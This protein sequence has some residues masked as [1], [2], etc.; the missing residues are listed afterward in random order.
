MLHPSRGSDGPGGLGQLHHQLPPLQPDVE[1]VQDHV[2]QDVPLARGKERV[3]RLPGTGQ[4]GQPKPV[5]TQGRI[6]YGKFTFTL[7]KCQSD[8]E[9]VT[10]NTK[11][12]SQ[13]IY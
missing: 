12:L 13:L 6:L 4:E 2:P 10:S 3:G 8:F 7:S 1:A 11:S 5:A 9:K